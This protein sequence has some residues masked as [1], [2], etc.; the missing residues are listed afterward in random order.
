MRLLKKELHLESCE[1]L[2]HKP[3]DADVLARDFSVR[4]GRWRAEDGWL[5][6]EN[7]ENFAAMVV[8]NADYFGNVMLDFKAAT[9]APC[10]HDINAMW[11]GSWNEQTNTRGVAYVAGVQGWWHGKVGF[12]KSPAYD[13]NVATALWD[14]TPGQEYHIQMGSIDGHVFVIVDGKLVLEVTDPNPIDTTKYG[15]IGFEAYCTRVKYR[16]L[17]VK[18]VAYDVVDE[19]YIPEFAQ[20]DD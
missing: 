11:N 2:Y 7:R 17:Y 18:R 19:K 9:V 1:I 13:L 8:S 15:K 3:F 4:G 16:D 20:T 12:E 6:G 10:T 14:F 5:I